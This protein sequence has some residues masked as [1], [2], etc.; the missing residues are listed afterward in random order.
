MY[1]HMPALLLCY[2][3]IS[4]A[5]VIAYHTLQNTILHTTQEILHE[6]MLFFHGDFTMNHF[7]EW[8][9]DGTHFSLNIG[10][11]K[12]TGISSYVFVWRN[13]L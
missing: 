6:K 5:G 2:M 12:D 7:K 13:V 8:A 4:L 1:V 11:K 9:D 3:Y 10:I